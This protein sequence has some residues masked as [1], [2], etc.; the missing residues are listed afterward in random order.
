MT[1][2][3]PKEIS[4]RLVARL[5]Q[6]LGILNELSKSKSE[7]NSIELANKMNTTAVQVRRDL[8]TFG[9]FG[10]RGRGYDINK[11]IS[12][13]E[14]ILGINNESELIL[15][16]YGKMGSTIASNTNTLGKGFKLVAIFEKDLTKIGT[17]IDGINLEV[18]NVKDI[19]DYL[20]ENKVDIAV[21]AVNSEYAQEFAEKLVEKGIKAILNMTATKLE[22]P[23]EIS[24]V[25]VDITAKLQELNFWRNHPVSPKGGVG[26][27]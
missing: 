6:Y 7:V 26:L 16:G 12:I 22:L 8:S 21:L 27:G 24:V 10:V 18:Q 2:Y 25:N 19:D 4:N 3:N 15:I 14:D 20:V 9:E 1:K 11:L 5:T 13:I 17:K 23:V